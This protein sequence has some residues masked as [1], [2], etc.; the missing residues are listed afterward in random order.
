VASIAVD[1]DHYLWFALSR[2]RWNPL[3]TI[4]FFNEPGPPQHAAT[5]VL[6][7]RWALLTI[8]LLALRHREARAALLGMAAHV[9]LDAYHDRRMDGIRLAALLR[10]DHTCRLCGTRGADLGTHLQWQ[11]KLFPS[12]AS[13]HQITLCNTCHEAAHGLAGEPE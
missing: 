6:H 5:R 10:D 12:Y 13:Q 7:G 8:G 11:P 4:R 9:A 1:V 3:A 2:N